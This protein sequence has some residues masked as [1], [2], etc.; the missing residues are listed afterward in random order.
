MNWF[1]NMSRQPISRS[2]DNLHGDNEGVNPL[3]I[4]SLTTLSIGDELYT[5]SKNRDEADNTS[6][7]L[8][9]NRQTLDSTLKK[10]RNEPNKIYQNLPDALHSNKESVEENLS[11]RRASSS[12]LTITEEQR[13]PVNCKERIVCIFI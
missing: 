1:V 7:T 6:K 3:Y 12:V 5:H 2:S 4:A 8:P 10:N 11:K 13:C 9:S